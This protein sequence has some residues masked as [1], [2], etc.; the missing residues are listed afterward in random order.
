MLPFDRDALSPRKVEFQMIAAVY[1]RKS[2]EQSGVADEQKSVACQV[3]HARQYAV[4]KGW[5]VEET[6]IYV[7]D[8]VSGA[9]F[10][11]RPG[12]LRLMNT[13]KPRS[14][15]TVLIMS[16]VSRLGREQIETAWALKQLSTAG[17]TVF[18]YL[19]DRELR[20][21]SATDKFLLSA[22]NFAAEIE[23]E[24]ARVRVTDAMVRKA[25]GGFVTGGRCFGYRNVEV[26]AADGRRSHVERRIDGEE[27]AIVR[28]IFSRCA[29]GQGIKQIAKALNA[30]G[31]STSQP[32]RG[33]CLTGWAP[34]AIRSVL[35]RRTYL[36]EVRY[37]MTKK[38]D[39]W[40]QRRT[41]SVRCRTLW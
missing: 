27:A 25:R 9:E 24:N 38:R 18:S 32:R 35:Y 30:R 10:A 39:A 34:S 22:V 13:L 7:D 40:G 15:F 4:R 28:E 23:R 5:T 41:G 21:D 17:V 26:L 29:A 6:Y 16:E 37:G 20:M 33:S 11:N 19:D 2:T 3:E 12:F 1:A 31:V 8:G 36:G 14:P